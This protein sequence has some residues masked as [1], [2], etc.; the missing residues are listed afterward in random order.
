MM[1][2]KDAV[3]RGDRRDDVPVHLILPFP[4][5]RDR[6]QEPGNVFGI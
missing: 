3:W 2:K 5:S 4:S 6:L 1:D